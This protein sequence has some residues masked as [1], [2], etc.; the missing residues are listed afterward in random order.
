MALGGLRCQRG[1]TGCQ[2]P[3][4]LATDSSGGSGA[5]SASQAAVVAPMAI[6]IAIATAVAAAV[7]LSGGR[8]VGTAVDIPS[9]I[10]LAGLTRGPHSR[11]RTRQC[12]ADV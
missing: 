3:V 10:S 11:A 1:V 2:P 5:L 8:R 12:R 6:A 9:F 7:V 4:Q